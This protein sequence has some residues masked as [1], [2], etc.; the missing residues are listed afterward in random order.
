MP[1][2]FPGVLVTN[3]ARH[4][5]THFLPDGKPVVWNGF[6]LWSRSTHGCGKGEGEVIQADIVLWSCTG[7][8]DSESLKRGCGDDEG[9]AVQAEV[10]LDICTGAC[11][12]SPLKRGYYLQYAKIASAEISSTNLRQVLVQNHLLD[13]ASLN[14]L[15]TEALLELL[16]PILL[17][18]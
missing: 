1:Y 18:N 2:E 6:G 12:T 9:N 11:G 15:S 13:E 8:C 5:A 17:E 4:V 3:R 7:V 10:V 14:Q 16:G